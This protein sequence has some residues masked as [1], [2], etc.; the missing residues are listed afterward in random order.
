MDQTIAINSQMKIN[1]HWLKIGSS[2]IYR[3]KFKLLSSTRSKPNRSNT[4]DIFGVF[5][6]LHKKRLPLELK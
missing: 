2:W 3:I 1:Q 4:Q 5:L 6:A